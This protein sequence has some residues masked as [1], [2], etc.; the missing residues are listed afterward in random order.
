MWRLRELSAYCKVLGAQREARRGVSAATPVVD[1]R[2]SSARAI[3]RSRTYERIHKRIRQRSPR[4]LVEDR[5]LAVGVRHC[6]PPPRPNVVAPIPAGVDQAQFGQF[7][8]K[9]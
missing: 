5:R 4:G 6:V 9:R 8:P 7:E 1:A 2:V 3:T